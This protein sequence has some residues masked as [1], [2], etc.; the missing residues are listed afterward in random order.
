MREKACFVARVPKPDGGLLA[1]WRNVVVIE[2]VT[3]NWDVEGR[4]S[5]GGS[6]GCP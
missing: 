2:C 5:S 1:C 4:V 3:A 6:V